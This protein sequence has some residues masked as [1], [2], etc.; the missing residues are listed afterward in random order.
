MGRNTGK[1]IG[2]LAGFFMGGPLG[3]LVGMMA[4]KYFIDE[5]DL[6]SLNEDDF[7]RN[8][9]RDAQYMFWV[10]VSVLSAKLS[11]A[12]GQVTPEEVNVFRSFLNRN[13]IDSELQKHLAEVF[14]EAK[15][16]AHDYHAYADDIYKVM[17]HDRNV[18]SEI[19]ML[20]VN[21]AQA[22]GVFHPNEKQMIISIARSFRMSE[23]DLHR[24]F[25]MSEP[26]EDPNKIYD[27]LGI[28]KGATKTEI[29]SAYRKL[30]KEYHP[31]K[32]RSQNVPDSVIENAKKRMREINDAYDKLMK[33]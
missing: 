23:Y 28:K 14:N 16:D 6:S 15:Q 26:A 30:V 33:M 25:A 2:G 17:R 4:G 21:I 13:R 27:V 1:W 10:S 11:K 31:D 7:R 8:P 20:L 32:L 19:I 18:L 12:D 22:D 9:N 29:K 3:A 24:F 5:N